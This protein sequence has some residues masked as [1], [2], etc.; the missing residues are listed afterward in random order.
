MNMK[1]QSTEYGE[2]F[3]DLLETEQQTK[4]KHRRKRLLAIP[5]AVIASFLF[6]CLVSPSVTAPWA[7]GAS[8]DDRKTSGVSE[9][10]TPSE[11]QESPQESFTATLELFEGGIVD[12]TVEMKPK[13]GDMTVHDLHMS[14]IG[15]VVYK[16]T[17][18]EV[19]TV[20]PLGEFAQDTKI[21]GN[22]V[23]GYKLH[24]KGASP[25]YEMI[26][27]AEECL[28]YTQWIDRNF[29]KTYYTESN[30]EPLEKARIPE[31]ANPYPLGDGK[32][33]FT[34]YSDTAGQNGYSEILEQK[35]VSET[36]FEECAV[37]S[38]Q[39][40]ENYQFLGWAIHVGNPYDKG[41]NVNLSEEYG[42][43][44][45]V[46]ALI[47]I[48]SKTVPVKENV[49]TKDMVEQVP[50]SNDGVRYINVHAVWTKT[51]PSPGEVR[52]ILD[53]GNANQQRYAA[54]V[55]LDSRGFIYLCCYPEPTWP[56]KTFAGWVDENNRPVELLVCRLSFMDELHDYDG[57]FTGYDR[58]S[59]KVVSLHATW[60]NE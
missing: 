34:F 33:R 57:Q 29:D 51:D 38:V 4:K 53:N 54:D 26:G 56:G 15:M 18:D 3:P 60:E 17:G 12:V 36:E 6:L 45:P 24:Y 23:D 27:Q 46:E 52:L 28:V 49:I 8:T 58:Y 37:P 9:Q 13:E 14:I 40:P 48:D 39:T 41:S 22:N 50:V 35:T 7:S 19:G 44:P 11:A 20:L 59:N 47:T 55:P 21:Y 2:L 16:N 1:N 30:R 43:D 5:A 42:G 25:A 10:K 31:P 32:I